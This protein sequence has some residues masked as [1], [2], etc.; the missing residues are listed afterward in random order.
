MNAYDHNGDQ[1]SVG[2]YVMCLS[3][4]CEPESEIVSILP[5]NQIEVVPCDDDNNK[6][7]TINADDAFL[8]L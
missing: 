6:K 8:L 4:G 2:D 3:N 7:T 5:D 1:L